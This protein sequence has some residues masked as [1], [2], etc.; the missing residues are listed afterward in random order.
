MV[1]KNSQISINDATTNLHRISKDFTKSTP[2]FPQY[3][4]NV[5]FERRVIFNGYSTF[6]NF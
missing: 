4:I 6:Y 3:A 5:G 1:F 2:N